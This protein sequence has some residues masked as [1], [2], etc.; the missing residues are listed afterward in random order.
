MRS[1]SLLICSSNTS[2][3]NR[4]RPH[5]QH[6]S[7]LIQ[8]LC[9]KYSEL[10]FQTGYLD[11]LEP[12]ALNFLFVLICQHVITLN[13]CPISQGHIKYTMLP[14][15]RLR[16]CCCYHFGID[17]MPWASAPPL[18]F[19][20]LS[21]FRKIMSWL[22]MLEQWTGLSPSSGPTS[23]SAAIQAAMTAQQEA[24]ELRQQV[25]VL[26]ATQQDPAG[27]LGAPELDAS[28][29]GWRPQTGPQLS[30]RMCAQSVYNNASFSMGP[31]RSGGVTD[32]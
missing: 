19:S 16:F 30:H 28:N 13:L 32:I 5:P 27:H 18:M 17:R 14:A 11:T 31:D 6:E 25:E 23:G 26:Q 9:A 24:Q 21:S 4:C 22:Q 29:R 3:A 1:S 2:N 8:L 10:Q 7:C 20:L 12:F 15:N